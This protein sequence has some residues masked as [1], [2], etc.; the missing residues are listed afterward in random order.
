[1]S[2]LLVRSFDADLAGDGRTIVG[3]IV[4]FDVE[5]TVSD[6]DRPVPYREVWRR[7]AF[8]HVLRAPHLVRMVYE[9]DDRT[10]LN[11]VGHATALEE[12]DDGLH[13]EFRAV[14]GLSVGAYMH[15]RGSRPGP[16]GEV[17]RVRVSRLAHVALTGIPAF[18]DAEVLAVRSGDPGAS[19]TPA[20]AS[21]LDWSARARARFPAS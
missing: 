8:R 16:T 1:M 12:R 20:L 15:E 10:I 2:E 6:P 19:E 21:V 4:P 17:E 14:G 13:G 11:V 7:G 3:R 5:A 18:S 9:H